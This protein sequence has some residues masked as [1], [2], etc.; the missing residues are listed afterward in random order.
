LYAGKK[1]LRLGAGEP[2]VAGMSKSP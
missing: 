2:G 1:M